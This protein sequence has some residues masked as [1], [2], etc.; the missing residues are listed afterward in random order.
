MKDLI[1][2]SEQGKIQV[3]IKLKRVYRIWE[4]KVGERKEDTWNTIKIPISA[5]KKD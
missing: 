2:F 4:K 3:I 5:C 1:I